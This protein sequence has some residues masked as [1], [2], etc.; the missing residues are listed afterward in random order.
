VFFKST[1]NLSPCAP[2]GDSH[3][4]IIA[5]SPDS[6]TTSIGTSNPSRDSSKEDVTSTARIKNEIPS[7]SNKI[8]KKRSSG[9]TIQNYVDDV[10]KNSNSI[11]NKGTIIDNINID[12]ICD[13]GVKNSSASNTK[14]NDSNDDIIGH[15]KRIRK[16]DIYT[17]PKN[18]LQR[19]RK[20]ESDSLNIPVNPS[21]TEQPADNTSDI[22]SHFKDQRLRDIIKSDNSNDDIN[23]LTMRTR[24][25]DIY[26]HPK[27]GL[28]R[29]RKWESDS[30]NIPVNPSTTEQPADD[31]SHSKD[32]RL[33]N[34][35]RDILSKDTRKSS[36]KDGDYDVDGVYIVKKRGRD[37]RDY[38]SN[39]NRSR[40]RI[41]SRNRDIDRRPRSRR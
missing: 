37:D 28:Q 12:T 16:Q 15:T 31:T 2:I 5:T 33:R 9:D 25:Q 35:V 22:I 19:T 32:Q 23:G 34:T 10:I 20:W 14:I 1:S 24:K 17:H 18:G 36:G 40:D 30:L 21:T 7:S 27:N 41:S 4:A 39:R 8:V 26:T 13:D 29:T 6:S 11:D 38:D 3:T